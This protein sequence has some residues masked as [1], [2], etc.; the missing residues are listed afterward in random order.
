MQRCDG[1]LRRCAGAIC[2]KIKRRSEVVGI[3]PN[4][5]AVARLIDPSMG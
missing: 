5:A 4:E 3:F 2:G 1:T